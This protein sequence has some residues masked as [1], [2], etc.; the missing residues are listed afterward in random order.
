MV[1]NSIEIDDLRDLEAL[2]LRKTQSGIESRER[3][4]KAS[5][6]H[7]VLQFKNLLRTAV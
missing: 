5:A 7:Y 6:I 2:K 1:L 3:L 4:S